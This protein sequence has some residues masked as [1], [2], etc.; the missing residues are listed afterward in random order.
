[1]PINEP[2]AT[3]QKK[4]TGDASRKPPAGSWLATK[5]H[6][7]NIGRVKPGSSGDFNERFEIIKPTNPNLFMAL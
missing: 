6:P 2:T 4:A 1:L 5:T 7:E 3:A